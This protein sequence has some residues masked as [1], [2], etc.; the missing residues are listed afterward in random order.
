MHTIAENDDVECDG[1]PYCNEM[2]LENGKP[3]VG[4]AFSYIED[5]DLFYKECGRSKKISTRKRSSYATAQKG[6]IS[7]VIFV[8]SCEGI[9]DRDSNY[10][11]FDG[12]VEPEAEK[13]R[14]Q[15]T[16]TM[17]TNCKA[18]MHIVLD[19]KRKTWYV[20][21]FVHEHNHEMVSPK[22]RALMRSNKYMPLEA[23]SMAEAFNK[24]KLPVGKVVLLFGQIE[25]ATFTPRDVY[26]HL[27]TV[28]KSLLDVGDA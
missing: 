17:R 12:E 18:M 22:K 6:G 14:K 4:L 2:P 10:D 9:C 20:N 5:A 28:R 15:N 26:N 16:S 8:C 23:K 1:M 27:R 13:R 19:T 24:N 3:Y 25:N 11:D 7:R 21:T